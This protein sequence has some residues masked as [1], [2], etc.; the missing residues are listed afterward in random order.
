MQ[1]ALIPIAAFLLALPASVQ[2][3][4]GCFSGSLVPMAICTDSAKRKYGKKFA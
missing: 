4:I 3:L 2:R 1:Q